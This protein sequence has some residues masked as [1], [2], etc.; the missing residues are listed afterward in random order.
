MSEIDEYMK[1]DGRR[2]SQKSSGIGIDSVSM[3]L[4]GL[5]KKS[6]LRRRTGPLG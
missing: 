5:T 4:E 6:L 3:V 1:I 2:E